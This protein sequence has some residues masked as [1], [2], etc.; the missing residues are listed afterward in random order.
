PFSFSSRATVICRPECRICPRRSNVRQTQPSPAIPRARS[1]SR[2][3][4]PPHPWP[5]ST[6]GTPLARPST[7]PALRAAATGASLGSLLVP[8]RLHHDIFANQPQVRILARE[9]FDGVGRRG[10]MRPEELQRF[11]SEPLAV[12]LSAE[13]FH[14]GDFRPAGAADA[15]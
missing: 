10:F 2:S 11:C 3:W 6:P 13:D 7:V 12:R 5:T 1:R 15:P 4:L 14:G 9:R 8:I